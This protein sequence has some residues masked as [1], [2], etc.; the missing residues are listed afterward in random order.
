MGGDTSPADYIGFIQRRQ[1]L[2]I[3]LAVLLE[4][5]S[6]TGVYKPDDLNYT[7]P[8]IVYRR[9]IDGEDENKNVDS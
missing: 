7:G 1:A 5:L 6:A 4:G 2:A 9:V 8:E 3:G